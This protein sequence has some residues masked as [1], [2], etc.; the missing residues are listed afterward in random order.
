[1]FMII[2]IAFSIPARRNVMAKVVRITKNLD[3][4]LYIGRPALLTSRATGI[5]QLPVGILGVED[6]WGGGVTVQRDDNGGIL[7]LP[8]LSDLRYLE[9]EK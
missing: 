1:M 3:A 5:F 9:V 4:K 6:E 7:D 8:N 2:S